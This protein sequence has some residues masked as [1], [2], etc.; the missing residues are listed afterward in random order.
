MAARWPLAPGEGPSG[1][2]IDVKNHRLF[3]VCDNKQMI[4]MDAENGKVLAT[5]AIGENPDGAAFDPA[6]GLAFS[7]NG[8][9]TLTIV[10]EA[11]PS[12]FSVVQTVETMRG[13]RTMVL[14]PKT[15]N[16][17]LPAAKFEASTSRP[18][19]APRQRPGMVPNSFH[20]LV[21]GKG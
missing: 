7:S 5:P 18:K 13:A 19:D 14:D 16:V 20:I 11:S 10:R 9:G 21:V 4:V 3:S 1:L 6:A 17:F 8:D 12:S 2:A 15:H